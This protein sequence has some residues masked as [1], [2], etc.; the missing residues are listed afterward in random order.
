MFAIIDNDGR[1]CALY[2]S[3]ESAEAE[4]GEYNADPFNDDGTPDICGPYRVT[5]W[6]VQP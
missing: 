5:T 3:R 6:V 2:K 4:A 1:I